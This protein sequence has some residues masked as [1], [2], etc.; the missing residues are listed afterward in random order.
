MLFSLVSL[1]GNL[2]LLEIC[3]TLSSG[4]KQMEVNALNMKQ[5]ELRV[6]VVPFR[7]KPSFGEALVPLFN[8]V[9]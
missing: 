5:S 6:I 4:L 1:S 2:S 9:V 7:N 3:Y 8:L